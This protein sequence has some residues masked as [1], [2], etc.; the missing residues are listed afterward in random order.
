MFCILRF[1]KKNMKWDSKK[2]F[3][4]GYIFWKSEELGFCQRKENK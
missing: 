2:I 4:W 1:I 3:P